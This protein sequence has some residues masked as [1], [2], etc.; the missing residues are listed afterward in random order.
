MSLP[1]EPKGQVDMPSGLDDRPTARDLAD[2]ISSSGAAG[3]SISRSPTPSPPLSPGQSNEPF[4]N[5]KLDER[6]FEDSKKRDERKAQLVMGQPLGA[7]ETQTADT[8]TDNTE[9]LAEL[10]DD[11]LDLELTHMRLRTLKGLGLER[12]TKVQRISLRQNL[13]SSLSYVDAPPQQNAAAGVTSDPPDEDELDDIDA[14]KKESDFPYHE[15]EENEGA[16]ARWPLS[17]LQDLEELDL[18]DNSL[19]SVRGLENLPSL[20]SLDLSFNLLRS[21]LPFDDDSPESAHAYPKLDHLYLIQNKLTRIEG[22]RHRTS[23]TYLEFGGNRI[24]AIENLPISANLQSLFLGKNKITKLEG[25]DGLTG[26]RTL[27]VQSEPSSIG[28]GESP[29]DRLS[30]GNRLTKIEGLDTLANLEELYLSHNGLTRIEGLRNNTKLTTLDVGN[31]KIEQVDVEEL[32]ALTELEEF[33]ANDNKIAV[34]PVLSETA[35][36]ELSTVYLEGNPVQKELAGAYHRKIM[37]EMPQVKQIDAVSSELSKQADLSTLSLSPRRPKSSATSGA[38]TTRPSKRT[39]KQQRSRLNQ[40][41]FDADADAA[42]DEQAAVNGDGA[43]FTLIDRMRNWR[44]DAMTQHLYSTAQFWGSK[45]FHLT[46]NP[47]DA[48]WLAQTHFLTHQYAQAERILTATRPSTSASTMAGRLTDTSLACRYLAAQCQVRLGKWDEALEMVGRQSYLG[49]E[50][51]SHGTGDGGI[52]LTASIAHLRGLIHLHLGSADLAKEAFIEALSR[53]VKCFEAFQML[54]G[55]EMMSQ[56]EEWEFIHSL[57]YFAQTPEDYEFVQCLYTVR[58]KKM[59]H[60][61][62]MDLARRKLADE[63]GLLD[64]ADVL[65]SRAEELYTSLQYEEAY[66]IT[67]VIMDKHPSHKST[68]PVHLACMQSLPHLR[69]KLFLLAHE[70]VDNDPDDAI[71]WYAVGLWYYSG[72][73]WEESRRFFG[74]SVLIDSRFGPAWLAFAHSYAFEGEHD[75]AITAYSTALR[76]LQGSY[77]PLLFIGMQHLSLM[78]LTLADEYLTT[79]NKSS[80]DDPLVVNELG[81][82]SFQN[83]KYK[84]AL[85]LFKRGLALSRKIKAVSTQDVTTYINLGHTYRKLDQ[86][87]DAAW[88]FRHAISISPRCAPAY[89]A[90]GLVEHRLGNFQDSIKR[91]HEALGIAPH[92]PVACDLLKLVLDDVASAISTQSL[93]FPG[94]PAQT[95]KSIDERVNE[96][97]RDILD[98]V[99]PE[100][101]DDEGDRPSMDVSASMDVSM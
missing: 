40:D 33:W 12:F 55:G 15:R 84:D 100:L 61:A 20:T 59:S 52:R 98:G 64:D 53:D 68:L 35:H 46:A 3:D 58:L 85:A 73:R 83:G 71:A 67:S 81:V 48:F 60:R 6:H 36:P 45:V 37:L 51:F 5:L 74:K 41:S 17:G 97:D 89:S 93:P 27:S 94:L 1:L 19:K 43:P 23:L 88:C 8:V 90:L 4:S 70:L 72:H 63:F 25:L 18:Y 44:N 50:A 69:S 65:F 2:V 16:T 49:V 42:T 22:V 14:K 95:L 86:L 91:Y 31:N 77:L 7:D 32:S 11:A 78:N 79:A 9:I 66:K 24:R 80:P 57:P 10:P 38:S 34:L 101:S 92:D 30:A 13:L 56:T 54:V 47:D 21:I 28:K 29:V 96:L 26:L 82:V 99:E 76:H 75:Q 39:S 87:K 62:E